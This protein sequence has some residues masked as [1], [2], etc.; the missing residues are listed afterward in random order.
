MVAIRS[1]LSLD[2][3]IYV[4][5]APSFG[6]LIS[7]QN[8]IKADV[9]WFHQIGSNIGQSGQSAFAVPSSYADVLSTQASRDCAAK[10]SL[11]TLSI[12]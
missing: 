5:F 11:H 6:H 7:C 8:P 3:S 9:D 10:Y 4:R 12:K 1:G 2:A